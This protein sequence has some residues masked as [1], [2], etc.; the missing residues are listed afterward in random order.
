MVGF[1]H[2]SW[3]EIF[4]EEQRNHPLLL[5]FD[6]HTTHLAMVTLKLATKENGSVIRLPAYCTA[7][8]QS[9][10]VMS[11]LNHFKSEYKK[12][13]TKHS[14]SSLGIQALKVQFSVMAS[15]IS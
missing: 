14:P 5:L 13:L 10:D 7:L 9:V 6:G 1:S 3:F 12:E 15:K 2:I 4:A 8:V 11:C